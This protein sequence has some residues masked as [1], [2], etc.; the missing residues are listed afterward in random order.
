MNSYNIQICRTGYSFVTYDDIQA[1]T[2]EEA[3]QIAIAQAKAET[4]PEKEAVYYVNAWGEN[5][6]PNP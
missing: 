2:P 1:N 3:Y 4:L 5:P 6:P